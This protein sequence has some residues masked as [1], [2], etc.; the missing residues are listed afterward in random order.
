MRL[1]SQNLNPVR[2]GAV[3]TS[4]TKVCAYQN[5]F[6]AHIPCKSRSGH[7]R[8]YAASYCSHVESTQNGRRD[9]Y[10]P[11]ITPLPRHHNGG[12]FVR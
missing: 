6:A 8:F 3:F 4:V 9:C 12:L 1:K 10:S 7:M 2:W 5:I 11:P